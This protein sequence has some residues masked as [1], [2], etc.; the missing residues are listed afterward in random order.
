MVPDGKKSVWRGCEDE[1]MRGCED[2]G[3]RGC[4]DVGM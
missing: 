1:G 2:V 3:M 4:E